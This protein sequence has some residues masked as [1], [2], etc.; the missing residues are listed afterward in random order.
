LYGASVMDGRFKVFSLQSLVEADPK[1][2]KETH[3]VETV[4]GVNDAEY[5][6]FGLDSEF[7][8]AGFDDGTLGVYDY[9]AKK[10]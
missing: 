8:V 3:Y 6:S 7:I 2:L 5:F 9:A 4:Y 1:H 10:S